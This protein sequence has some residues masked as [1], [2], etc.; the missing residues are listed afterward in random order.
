MARIRVSDELWDEIVPLL[1]PEP[2]SPRGDGR[3]SGAANV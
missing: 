2:P 3:A 1:R